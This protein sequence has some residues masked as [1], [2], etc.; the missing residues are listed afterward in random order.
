MR[1]ALFLYL[2]CILIFYAEIIAC[3]YLGIPKHGVGRNALG[4]GRRL[5]LLIEQEEV[6]VHEADEVFE[7]PSAERERDEPCRDGW[8]EREVNVHVDRAVRR[9][10]R[11]AVACVTRGPSQ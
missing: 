1:P 6:R 3:H 8:L 9:R 10:D 11:L 7:D 4:K 5:K 2:F